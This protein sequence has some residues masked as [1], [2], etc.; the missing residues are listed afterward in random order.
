M[1]LDET[2]ARHAQKAGA[3]LTERTSVT[4]PVLDERTG[5]VQTRSEQPDVVGASGK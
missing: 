4:A 1:D 5:C 3:R 2:L